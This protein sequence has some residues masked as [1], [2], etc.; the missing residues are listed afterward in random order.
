[1]EHRAGWLDPVFV[2]LSVVA[3]FGAVWIALAAALALARRKSPG[4][5]SC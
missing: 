4:F 3:Y 5:P 2:G 1:V